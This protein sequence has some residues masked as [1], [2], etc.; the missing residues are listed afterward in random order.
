MISG[1][2]GRHADGRDYGPRHRRELRRDR[3][4]KNKFQQNADGNHET[5]Q[6]R[7]DADGDTC[8]L[9]AR[10]GHH[11]SQPGMLACAAGI[12]LP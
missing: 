1:G 5:G 2:R 9:T 6:Q 11:V 8:D 4:G 12:T 7:Q 10:R 3:R